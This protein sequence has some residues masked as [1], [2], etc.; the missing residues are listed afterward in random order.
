MPNLDATGPGSPGILAALIAGAAIPAS[1]GL[2]WQQ[3]L[4]SGTPSSFRWLLAMVAA[5]TI[6]TTFAR[7]RLGA[8]QPGAA[9]LLVVAASVAFTIYCGPATAFAAILMALCAVSILPNGYVAAGNGQVVVLLAGLAILAA[10]IGWLLPFPFHGIRVYLASA[11]IL[12]VWRR[13]AIR[14]RVGRIWEEWSRLEQESPAWLGCLV[15]AA[16]VAGLGLWLPSMN[17]DDNTAH[18]ILPSQLLVDGY[19]HLDVSTQT[20]AVTPWANNV[21][22]GVAALL[23]GQEARA[24]VNVLWLLVGLNGAWRLATALGADTR[25]ALAAA[26]VYASLPLTGY[27]TTNMQVDG[28]SAAVLTQLAALL[29]TSGRTLPPVVLV[30]ALLGLLAALKAPNAIFA[31]PAMGWLGWLALRQRRVGW[32]VQVAAIA[33]LLAG[34]SYVYS[35]L[36]TG[37]PLFPLFNAT[38]KSGYFPPI[39]LVDGRWKAGLSWRSLWDLTYQTGLYGEHYAGAFGIATLALLPALVVEAMRRPASRYVAIWFVVSGLLMF[40]QIQYM[41]YLYPAIAILSTVGVVGLARLLPPKPFAILLSGLVVANFLLLPSTSW[42]L[43]DDPWRNLVLHGPSAREMIEAEK[44]PERIVLR[45]ILEQSPRACVLIANRDAPFGAIAGGRALV[46]RDPYDPRMA[47]SFD[48]AGGDPTGMRWQQVMA[49]TGVSHV[50]TGSAVGAPLQVALVARGFEKID[51]LGT[52]MVWASPD[53][54]R[55]ACGAGLEAV[56]DEAHRHFHP[57]DTH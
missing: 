16:F 31:F 32:L 7:H 48:W 4:F 2:A 34:S 37:N 6:A 19:Y 14:R 21:L 38:F 25:G 43:R 39:D 27:F 55:R 57:W 15:A 35:I 5:V 24:A 52:A 53:L 1:I 12:C 26:I 33:V 56:R 44:I 13:N 46:V 30:G 47:K 22:N 40:A 41:R 49:S 54:W 9:S 28:A 8:G 51:V 3:G 18:L 17:F 36:V 45:R 11:T 42:L 10:V 29:V 50:I 23:A 20:W